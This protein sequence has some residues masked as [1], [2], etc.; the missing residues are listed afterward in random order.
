MLVNYN[1]KINLEDNGKHNL[2]MLWDRKKGEHLYSDKGQLK[3]MGFCQNLWYVLSQSYRDKINAT[4]TKTVSALTLDIKKGVI[5]GDQAE[6]FIAE[7]FFK[8]LSYLSTRIYKRELSDH[9]VDILTKQIK[10][11]NDELPKTASKL[12]LQAYQSAKL[13]ARLGNF[14]ALTGCSGS[15]RVIKGKVLTAE[16]NEDK[17]L[18]SGIFKPSE[19]D[20]LAE[21]NPK[22]AQKIKRWLLNNIAWA[23]KGS[24]FDTVAGQAYVAE[25]ATK[26]VET[27]LLQAVQAYLKTDGIDEKLHSLLNNLTLVTD[28]HVGKM[29][30]SH[31]SERVGSFQLW[32]QEEHEEASHALG[33]KQNYQPYFLG[34]KPSLDELKAQVPAELFDLLVIIDYLTAN[35]DR[36]GG[37]WFV[38]KDNNGKVTGIRLIDG[39]W[40]MAPKHPTAWD[41]PEL[42]KQYLWQ[43]LHL[44]KEKF[45]DLGRFVIQYMSKNQTALKTEINDLYNQ[46]FVNE[47]K[48]KDRV[49]R[50]LERLEVMSLLEKNCTKVELAQIRTAKEITSTLKKK[51]I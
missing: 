7:L 50:M 13:W 41:T 14:E 21:G 5:E 9:T 11:D 17:A 27:H 3:V 40:S 45:T 22:T 8:K 36:H 26:V 30:F 10:M 20:T 2:Q 15:Y 6:E 34:K 24:L 12:Y 19:E 37:N 35:S 29:G 48:N 44:A 42:G 28:T 23:F 51:D 47:T 16:G 1:I 39:G 46:H 4:L 32:V 31:H 33:L 49:D 25:A 38:V 18:T 43:N